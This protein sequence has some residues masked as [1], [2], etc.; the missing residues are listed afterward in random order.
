MSWPSRAQRLAQ[1][2]QPSE[3]PCARA[4]MPCQSGGRQKRGVQVQTTPSAGLRAKRPLLGFGTWPKR[5]KTIEAQELGRT[6]HKHQPVPTSQPATKRNSKRRPGRGTRL[7]RSQ[8]QRLEPKP[9]PG[10]K[11][12]AAMPC[13]SKGTKETKPKKRTAGRPLNALLHDEMVG[14]CTESR[15]QHLQRHKGGKATCPRCRFYLF[16]DAWVSQHGSFVDSRRRDSSQPEEARTRIVWLQERPARWGGV[17]ALGCS[18]CALSVFRQSTEAGSAEEHQLIQ[19][20]AFPLPRLAPVKRTQRKTK[21][22]TFF[23][24][25]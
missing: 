8:N 4:P 16:G 14:E 25:W 15:E 9:K 19:T 17:W 5:Q 18:L 22:Q 7:K 10:P 20:A 2:C 24:K 13:R 6:E 21:T 3:L 11:P 23:F 1:S 12:R